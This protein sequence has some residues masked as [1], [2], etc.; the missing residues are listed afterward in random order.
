[1]DGLKTNERSLVSRR[2]VDGG[3][4]V[5]TIAPGVR[6]LTRADWG[7]DP[8]IV[9]GYLMNGAAEKIEIPVHHTVIVDNDATPD[10]WETLTEVKAK[11]RQ[12]QVI[13][14][15]ITDVPYNAVGFLMANGDLIVCEGR[16]P[17]RSGAHTIGHNRKGYGF[18]F[19]GNMEAMPNPDVSLWTP[20]LNRFFGWVKAEQ[21]PR[22]GNFSTGHQHGEHQFF[23]HQQVSNTACPGRAVIP[24]I[25]NFRY[26]EEDE[27]TPEEL[28][29][30]KVPILPRTQGDPTRYITVAELMHLAF[31]GSHRAVWTQMNLG[32]GIG[33][34]QLQQP[35]RA[36]WKA[37]E[38]I[39]R[40]TKAIG[41]LGEQL[42]SHAAEQEPGGSVNLDA[43]ADLVH[44]LEEGLR[45]LEAGEP[46]D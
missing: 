34:K 28:M 17:N 2:D 27:M 12:L 31:Y 6:Y 38:Q 23:P 5:I 43:V 14:A 35:L 8:S 46:D 44:E 37:W 45:D 32:P 10:L 39:P 3:A 30:M 1:M 36:G 33:M 42:A 24:Q 25:R 18:A 29:A 22:L 19:E 40:L 9:G 4:A 41:E 16:G 20:K 15:D 11:M 7:A 13:R 21:L 26:E